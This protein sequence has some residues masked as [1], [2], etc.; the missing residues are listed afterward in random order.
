MVKRKPRLQ[1]ENDVAG[2]SWSGV[3]AP[4]PAQVKSISE[5]RRARNPPI[6]ADVA[7]I[8]R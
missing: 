7:Q 1:C 3:R 6:S 2:I 4:L 5:R 8:F